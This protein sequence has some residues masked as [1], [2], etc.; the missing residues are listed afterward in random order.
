MTTFEAL[1]AA[2]FAALWLAG[3]TISFRKRRAPAA[4]ASI[5]F[6]IVALS[7]L[8]LV[9]VVVLYGGG[10]ERWRFILVG[11]APVLFAASIGF[12]AALLPASP[13]QDNDAA[14]DRI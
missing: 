7:W 6:M 12:V 10:V 9:G 2:L 4:I 5:G 3:L 1:A 14:Q 8:G 13:R 11:G